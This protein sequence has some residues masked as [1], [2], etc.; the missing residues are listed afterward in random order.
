[1][2]ALVETFNANDW[3]TLAVFIA[4]F[5]MAVGAACYKW[6]EHFGNIDGHTKGLEEARATYLPKIMKA[7]RDGAHTGR[8][9]ELRRQVDARN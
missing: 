9:I 5:S 8:L 6:G 2:I 4:L 1:M 3:I 7:K